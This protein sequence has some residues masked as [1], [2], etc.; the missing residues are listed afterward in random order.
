MDFLDPTTA[1][2]SQTRL[3]LGYCLVA[4]AIGIATLLLL[5][6]A[7]GYNIDRRG[8]V[9]QNGLVFVSSSPNGSAIY[10]NDKRY[11]SNTDTRVVAPA[12]KYTLRIS[13]TGYRPW[14]RPVWVAGG[15]V[16]HFDYPLLFPENLQT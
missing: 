6:Q 11:K 7:E 5:Y 15:D 2:R 12:G 14:E 4:L 13:Q 16:Q 1:R 8:E 9:I 10:L 3:L